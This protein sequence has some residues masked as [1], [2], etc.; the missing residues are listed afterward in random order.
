MSIL[1]EQAVLDRDADA[2]SAFYDEWAPDF[3]ADLTAKGY[4]APHRCAEALAETVSDR[5][6]AILDFG[7]GTGL[8]GKAFTHE[9]FRNI[10]G[11]DLSATMLEQARKTDIYGKLSLINAEATPEG[12]YDVI[13]AVGVIGL[14][15]PP[16]STFDILM[17]ALPKGGKLVF[18]FNDHAI[19]DPMHTG[20]LNEWIDCSTAR[21]LFADHGPHLPAQNMDSTV[22]VVEKY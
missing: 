16:S 18:S 4:A 21:V 17:H 6:V 15:A 5:N 7:C 20:R 8:S 19:A 1:L 9:G 14:G 13:S 22:Y 11:V 10:D 12:K 3:E 2:A